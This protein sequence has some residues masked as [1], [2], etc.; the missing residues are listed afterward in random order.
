MPF[1]IDEFDAPADERAVAAGKPA[2]I[3][4]AQLAPDTSAEAIVA[5]MLR[6]TVPIGEAS[7]VDEAMAVADDEYMNEVVER[8]DVAAHYQL[9]LRD[10]FFADPNTRVAKRVTYELRAWVRERLAELVGM[11]T[12]KKAAA[13]SDSDVEI[14]KA[15]ANFT[16]AHLHA[17]KLVADKLVLGGLVAP[18]PAPAPAPAAALPAPKAAGPAL[19]K[20][21]PAPGT[22][23]P[24]D[25]EDEPKRGRGRPPGSPNKPKAP[26]EPEMVQA[27]RRHADGTEEPLFDKDGNPRMVKKVVRQVAKGRGA[28]P[29]PDSPTKMAAATR[30]VADAQANRGTDQHGQQVGGLVEIAKTLPEY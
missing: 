17:L 21:G 22:A 7:S 14:V 28:I 20:R 15:L 8:L 1:N 19:V 18:T 30:Y 3:Q 13:L 5:S 4:P 27:V 10:S 25:Y 16:P 23:A 9:L 2:P 11:T 26:P 29:F 12:P 24:K 6:P